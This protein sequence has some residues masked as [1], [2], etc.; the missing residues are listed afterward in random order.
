[1]QVIRWTDFLSLTHARTHTHI[2]MLCLTQ[3]PHLFKH[4]SQRGTNASELLAKKFPSSACSQL[5]TPAVKYFLRGPTYSPEASLSMQMQRTGQAIER[6]SP[7]IAQPWCSNPLWQFI[8]HASANDQTVVWMG[9]AVFFNH[10]AQTW[11]M[12]FSFFVP[13][14]P[15]MLL[16]WERP[17]A[18]DADFFTNNFDV[19]KWCVCVCVCV[20][21]RANNICLYYYMQCSKW[22]F[23]PY[24]S[25][26]SHN[27]WDQLP[28]SNKRVGEQLLSSIWQ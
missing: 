13:N 18:L 2:Y 14:R 3:Q 10:T 7:G 27:E 28:S 5:V 22:Q 23:L 26:I 21:A 9:T 19:A 4:F 12:D 16:L 20:R 6:K 25:Y 24:L 17:H 8:T 11:Y 15:E 1:V